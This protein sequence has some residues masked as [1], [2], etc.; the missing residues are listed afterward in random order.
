MNILFIH[1][2]MPGPFRHL[3][4]ALAADHRVLFLTRRSDVDLPGVR[5]VT[6]KAPRP[7]RDETHPYLKAHEAAV[8]A[9]QQVAR[10]LIEL[11]RGGFVPDLVIAHPGWG[12]ALFVKD[13]LPAARLLGYCEFFYRG[14][15]L[16]IGFDPEDGADLDTACRARTRSAH[17]LL[18]LAAADRGLAPTRWQKSTHPEAFHDLIDVAHDGIDLDAVRTDGP[19]RLTLPDGHQ[20]AKGDEVVTFVAG[21]LEP[22][23][24]FRPFMRALPDLLRRRPDAH[25]VI[26]GGDEV[27]YGPPP[28]GH[29]CWR[30]AML[31]EVD[32]DPARVHFAGIL[33]DADRFALL[34]ASRA[35]VHLSYP[36][37]LSRSCLEA[38]A[39]GALVIG[40]DTPPVA[41]V[42][43]DGRNGLLVDFFDSGALADRIVDA[44]ARPEG[45]FLHRAAAIGTVR[46]RYALD[47]CLA[48]QRQL[49]AR[50]M[51]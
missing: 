45:Y 16:D 18:A 47:R 49:V 33:P 23:R 4:P 1:Q 27:S 34:R 12:E 5:R 26:V 48:V 8:L 29:R 9:G 39:L 43:E 20:V 6:Y 13:V 38:M 30:E 22:Y 21:N 7:P 10:A 2:N 32:V 42:I 50:L 3:A 35:H 11:K 40:S 46:E 14:A 41:E 19:A 25:V 31:A 24:G 51:G 17:L 15:G 28:V 37:T 36:F 44:L